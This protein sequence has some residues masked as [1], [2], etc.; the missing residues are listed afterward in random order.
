MYLLK[1]TSLKVSNTLIAGEL[2]ATGNF[3][4]VETCNLL[5]TFSD[6]FLFILR[7]FQC[8]LWQVI[9]LMATFLAGEAA[10]DE[11]QKRTASQRAASAQVMGEKRGRH[12]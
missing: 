10:N 1:R 5:R 4:T 11:R 12:G 7:G 2:C 3:P 6:S 8:F 9:E